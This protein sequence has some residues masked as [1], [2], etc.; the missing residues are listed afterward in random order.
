MTPEELSP[1]ERE[2]LANVDQLLRE[3][4]VW[5]DV[6]PALETK[7]VA[8]VTAEVSGV[9]LQRPGRSA[10]WRALV[11]AAGL[12]AAAAATITFVMT[13][14][15]IVKPDAAFALVGTKLAP[16]LSGRASF[17][18]RE[19]GVQ[20][21]VKMPGLPWRDGGEYYELWMHTCDGSEW[22]PAGTFH[23]LEYVVAWAGVPI[24]NYPILKVTRE[25]AGPPTGA[26][27]AP[28]KDVVAWGSL[29][30]CLK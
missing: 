13:R 7:V 24:K 5:E 8:A 20:I 30:T 14:S 18:S 6:D 10:R 17:S 2:V 1:V 26:A 23:D 25:V 28:S 12:G 3:R 27:Q 4:S 15:S 9:A 22:V 29:D 19:S 11:L 16:G 21:E